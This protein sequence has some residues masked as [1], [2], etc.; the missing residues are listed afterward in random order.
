MQRCA[1]HA[2]SL[3]LQHLVL[4]EDV[5]CELRG[6]T[7]NKGSSRAPFLSC[8]STQ[9]AEGAS[10]LLHSFP[11]RLSTYWLFF[12]RL[13]LGHLGGSSA[14]SC[15]NA[16]NSASSPALSVLELPVEGL[17]EMRFRG[18]SWRGRSKSSAET[19]TAENHESLN[20]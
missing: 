3:P 11:V 19:R 17:T 12:F 4:C 20:P 7:C 9:G 13:V 18:E 14:E 2:R 16:G 10:A 15:G 6:P 1:K 5:F 8:P